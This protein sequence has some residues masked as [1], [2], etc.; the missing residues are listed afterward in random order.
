MLKYKYLDKHLSQASKSYLSVGS[1]KFRI[2]YSN[3]TLN[4]DR[5]FRPKQI[6][7]FQIEEKSHIVDI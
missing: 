3:S 7:K 2:S 6:S 5:V 4:F 1:Q